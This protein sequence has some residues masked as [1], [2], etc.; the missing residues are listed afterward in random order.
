MRTFKF[1]YL[2]RDTTTIN[3]LIEERII[4]AYD[5]TYAPMVSQEFQKSSLLIGMVNNGKQQIPHELVA[6]EYA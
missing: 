5:V 1:P 6:P 2:F 4:L 3:R